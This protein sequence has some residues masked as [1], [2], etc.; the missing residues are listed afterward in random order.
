M[1]FTKVACF[2][3]TL[4][5]AA[6]KLYGVP[7]I[8]RWAGRI[9][10]MVLWLKRSSLAKPVLKEKQRLLGL[11]EHGVILDVKNRWNSLMVERFVEQFPALQAASMDPR[12]KR[13]MERDRLERMSADDLAKAEQFVRVMRVLYTSTICISAEKSPTL[14]QIL[15][16]LGKLQHH[17]TVTAQD[18]AFTQAIKEKIW[19]DLSQRYQGCH[20]IVV[21]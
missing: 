21:D 5:I 1:S 10:A 3:H 17:F 11:P 7:A 16:I 2:A 19:G 4:N 14:G 13:S 6:Q 18:S 20:M 15:P 8:A 9:R 12:L